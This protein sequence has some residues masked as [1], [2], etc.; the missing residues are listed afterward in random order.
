MQLT[1]E[2]R[3]LRDTAR[4]FARREL[5]PKAAARDRAAEF[6]ADAVAQLG[7]LGFLGML[8]PEEYGGAG[9]DHVGYALAMEEIA[10]GDGAVSTIMS[11][12]N[13]VGCM[14]LL[15]YGSEE[16]K[17]RFLVPMAKG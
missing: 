16:Q 6:P 14:P 4:E 15:Q 11:V 12:Q 1:D 2:H 13:S 9:A 17:Q 10:A 5:M 3:M 8:V 7:R